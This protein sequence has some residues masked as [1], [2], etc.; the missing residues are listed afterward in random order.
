MIRA[1]LGLGAN[2]GDRLETIKQAISLINE[3]QEIILLNKSAIYET[4]P[5][6][7]IDQPDF[8]NMVIEIATSLSPNELLKYIHLIENRLGR[9]REI[10]WG[11]RTI[12]IDI[13]LYGD[14]IIKSDDLQI[15]HPHLA[16]RLFVL[17]PLE[18]IYSGLIPGENIS[19]EKMVN[20]LGRNKGVV[21]Y[22][23]YK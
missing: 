3:H 19:I 16:E 1:F 12:D 23:Q 9:K 8:I 22:G 21:R 14:K 18:E 5:F 17:V 7:Y 6:G 2:L 4:Q 20:R 15:P 10:H 13:L 11:P